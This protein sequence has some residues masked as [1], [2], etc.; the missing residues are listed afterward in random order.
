MQKLIYSLKNRTKIDK[1]LFINF[2]LILEIK[3]LFFLIYY[4]LK[5]GFI[6][7]IIRASIFFYKA[8]NRL[9]KIIKFI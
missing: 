1:K 7:I 3:Y 4:L 8:N 2:N 9:K 6:L 5:K